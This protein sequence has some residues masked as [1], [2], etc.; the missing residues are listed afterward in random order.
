MKKQYFCECGNQ[1]STKN[2]KQCQECY[3]S[4]L[5]GSKNPNFKDG[6]TLEIYY[7][8]N[9]PKQI[10]YNTALYAGGIC[11]ECKHKQHSINM[12]GNN[13]PNYIDGRTNKNYF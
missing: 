12:S 6:R 2:A 8:K 3:T 5:R 4:N 9:C 7:C 11:I 1:K 10:D 13:H